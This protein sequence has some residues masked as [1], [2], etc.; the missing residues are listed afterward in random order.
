MTWAQYRALLITDKRIDTGRLAVRD[1]RPL[2][3]AVQGRFGVGPAVI[4]GIWGLESGF[5]AQTGDFHVVEALATLAWDGRRASFFRPELMAALKILDHGDVTP[6]RMTGSY[7][8]A[9][10]QPQFMPTSF[11]RYAVDF[12]GNGRRDIWTSRA[13]V[14]ASIANYLAQSGWRAGGSWGQAVALPTGFDTGATGREGRR[15]LADWARQGVRPIEGRWRA[16]ADTA[17]AVLL[18]DGAAGE[19]FVVYPNFGA[20]R[21]YN[22]SDYYALAVGLLGDSLVA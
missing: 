4:T 15:P 6:A 9:M 10:G 22:P 16:T 11:L 8:G 21:R 18:P 13:D 1:N 17:A 3:S 2:L 5:G 19:A 7:A 14:L 12:E 20:I